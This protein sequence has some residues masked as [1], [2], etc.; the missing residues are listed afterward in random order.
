MAIDLGS[1][2]GPYEVTAPLGEGGMGKVWRAHHTARKR[3][4]ALKVLPDAFASDLE[5][6]ARYSLVRESAS[7]E[8]LMAVA[9]DGRGESFEIGAAQPSFTIRRGGD[10]SVYVSPDG[11][12]ILVTTAEDQA[13]API[14][15]VVNWQ[16][17][18][19]SR[20]GR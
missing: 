20:G 5:R 4:D 11:Q 10:R 9:I 7:Y 8:R 14:T 13:S 18:L 6:S 17:A 1:R 15:V 12:R 19:G 16:S 3:D 2:V